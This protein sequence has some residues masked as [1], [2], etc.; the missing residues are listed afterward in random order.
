MTNP[1]H[2]SHF[3]RRVTRFMKYG[4]TEQINEKHI[5]FTFIFF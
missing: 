1:F 2:L 3:K 5:L 4:N